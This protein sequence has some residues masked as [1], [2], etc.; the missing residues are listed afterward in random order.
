MRFN[1][2][3]LY[4]SKVNNVKQIA[5]FESDFSDMHGAIRCIALTILTCTCK[6]GPESLNICNS[7][8]MA[9]K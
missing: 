9:P 5:A 7:L 6:M 1:L 2:T 3:R 4:D 8:L